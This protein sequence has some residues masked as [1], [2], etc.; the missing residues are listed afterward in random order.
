MNVTP[1]DA[2]IATTRKADFSVEGMTCGAC[3]T[4]LEKALTRATGVIDAAVNFA[5]ERAAV[6][7]DPRSTSMIKI[8]DVVGKAGFDVPEE[9]YSFG[10]G[11]MT[12]SA[13]SSRVEKALRAIPGV[14]AA[15]VNIGL[16]RADVRALAGIVRAEELA[17]A[18]Q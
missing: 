9:I 18:V 17:D 12:C 6:T 1:A 16:E 11:G 14:T 7:F 2:A 8:A 4:R 13:C 15:D 3:A 5:L 10:V